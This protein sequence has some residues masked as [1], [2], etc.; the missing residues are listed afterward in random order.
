MNLNFKL[1][2]LL[3]LFWLFGISAMA[4]DVIVLKN[5]DEIKSLVQEIGTEYVK[6]KRFDNQTGPIYNMAKTEIFMIKYENGTKD[7]FSEE[8]KL[9]EGKE[10][11]T[12]ESASV[13][14]NEIIHL[15]ENAQS[16]ED[17]IVKTGA[18]CSGF[19][20]KITHISDKYI[21]Y[22]NNGKEKK[23]KQ[24]KVAFT[25]TF[26][27]KFKQEKY[28]I[29]MNLQEFLSLPVYWKYE[30]GDNW[31]VFGTHSIS[32]LPHL[33]ESHQGIYDNYLKGTKLKNTGAIITGLSVIFLPLIIPGILIF[34][35]GYEKINNSLSTYYNYCVDLE[36]CAKYGIIITPYNVPHIFKNIKK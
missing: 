16:R 22:Y 35:T 14:N 26:D 2:T 24:K 11:F 10:I 28:P 33:K 31:I 15:Q 36:V 21:F 3:A 18:L 12:L 13:K 30:N 32:N 8:A 27:E 6:Y 23:I 20:T 19:Q 25:L 7:V 9:V 5:G 29:E 17:V 1:F 34:P 4:Q